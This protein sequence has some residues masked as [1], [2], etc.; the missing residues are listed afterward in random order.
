L[1]FPLR[2]FALS[3]VFPNL[4]IFLDNQKRR[5]ILASCVFWMEGL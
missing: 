2:S 4:L 5:A 3:L 1:I